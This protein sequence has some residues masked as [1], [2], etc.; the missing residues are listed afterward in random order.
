MAVVSAPVAA[1]RVRRRR[2]PIALFIA[3]RVTTGLLT[4]LV[5]SILIFIGTS[6]AP[7]DP[8]GVLLG[9]QGT[10]QAVHQ[11]DHKLGLDKPKVEQY[12]KW[13]GG[14][15]HGNLGKSMIAVSQGVTPSSIWVISRGRILNTVVLALITMMLLLPI[16]LILGVIA[17][18]RAGR[19]TDHVIST[20]TLMLVAVPEFV[21]GTLLL[22]VLFAGTHLLPADSIIPP[23]NSPLDD[24]KLLVMP[25]LTLLLTSLPWTIRFVRVGTIE[26]LDAGYVQ[27]AR[28]N[29]LRER[30]VLSRYALRN[31]L[32]PSIQIFAV[33]FQYLFGGVIVTEVVFSY[34]GIGSELVNAVL[35]HDITEVQTIALLLGAVYIAINILADLAVV[36]I[37]PKLRTAL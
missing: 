25:V 18:V 4:L 22:A 35:D 8:A 5:V 29:G 6:V 30:T 28:L 3:R 12:E 9:Q 17:A 26:V 23:G 34:P 31:A 10:P 27:S 33:S 32:A 16:S 11:L 21:V 19:F 2:H 14:V 36:L 15:V 7:G 37:T 13:L 20:T 24:P 1:P